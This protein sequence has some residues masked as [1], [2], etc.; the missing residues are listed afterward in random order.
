MINALGFGLGCRLAGF[1]GGRMFYA[2]PAGRA[3]GAAAA[4]KRVIS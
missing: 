3:T 2:D 4:G 1:P